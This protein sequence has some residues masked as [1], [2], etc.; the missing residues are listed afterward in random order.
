MANEINFFNIFGYHLTCIDGWNGNL[1][2]ITIKSVER[3]GDED[4]AEFKFTG[5]G[6]YGNEQSIWAPASLVNILFT[7]GQAHTTNTI[8]HCTYNI[9]WRFVDGR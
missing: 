6:Y 7:E 9:E 8:G 2:H 4:C 5:R 1:T 3:V